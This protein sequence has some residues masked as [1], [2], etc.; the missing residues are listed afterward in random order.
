MRRKPL[1]TI[2]LVP[3]MEKLHSFQVYYDFPVQMM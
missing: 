2:T 3:E 1:E